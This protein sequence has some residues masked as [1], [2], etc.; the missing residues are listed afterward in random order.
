MV[1]LVSS[2]EQRKISCLQTNNECKEDDPETCKYTASMFCHDQ[3]NMGEKI[4][5]VLLFT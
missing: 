2:G 4:L 5:I 1:L 3:W